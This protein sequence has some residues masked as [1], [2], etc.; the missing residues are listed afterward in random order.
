[1]K[2]RDRVTL[3]A[4]RM[5]K[6]ALTMKGVEKGRDPDERESQQ[7][8]ATL[9]KQRRDSIDQFT[10]GGRQDLAEKEA[11]EIAVLERYLPA[12]A[13]AED[14]ARAVDA[15]ATE[16][17]AAGPKDFGK[18]MKAAMARLS[19]ASVDGKVVSEAVRARLGSHAG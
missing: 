7:V 9:V 13:S 10:K 5:L 12:A 16:V 11:A 15:A 4:L 6:T 1:M 3:D 14:I 17:G 18:V 2:S 19:D 8:V